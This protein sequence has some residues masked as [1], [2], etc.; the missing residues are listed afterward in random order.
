MKTKGSVQ[1]HILMRKYIRISD[2]HACLWFQL[3]IG[4]KPFGLTKD[5]QL[6]MLSVSNHCNVTLLLQSMVS[7]LISLYQLYMV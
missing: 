6:K 4:R 5:Y 2:Q 1:I 7:T 3:P